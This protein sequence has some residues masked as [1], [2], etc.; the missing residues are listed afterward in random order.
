MIIKPE[1]FDIFGIFVF[2]YLFL[3]SF[4]ILKNK[5][6]PPNWTLILIM[7]IAVFGLLVDGFIVLNSY[8]LS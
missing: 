8:I 3:F 7:I 1:F 4:W 5:K 2:T 6:L